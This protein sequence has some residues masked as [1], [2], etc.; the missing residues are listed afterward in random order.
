MHSFPFK[1]WHTHR[2][3]DIE[4]IWTRMNI[5]YIYMSEVYPQVGGNHAYQAA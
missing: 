4:R 3:N 2:H 5:N 1:K